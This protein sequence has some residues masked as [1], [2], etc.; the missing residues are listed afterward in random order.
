MRIKR[1]VISIIVLLSLLSYPGRT[2]GQSPPDI[3]WKEIKTSRFQIIFPAELEAEAQ[4]V[5]NMLE[6]FADCQETTMK[7]KYSSIPVV[8]VNQSTVSNGFVSHVPL[9]SHWYS[10]PSAFSGTEWYKTLAVH[11]GRHIVQNRKLNAGFGKKLWSLCLGDVGT[12]TFNFLYVPVWFSEGDAVLSETVFT[13]GGRGRISFFDLWLRTQELSGERFS[14]DRTYLG[15]YND[16]YIFA[17]HYK[18]GYLLVTRAC[19]EYGA[20]VW[21]K[22]LEETGKYVIFPTF[23]KALTNVTGKSIRQLYN[24]TMDEAGA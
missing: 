16:P 3:K 11:E 5:A 21:D 7:S 18:I 12:A 10:T 13:N 6:H 8:L 23:D 2:T 9:M 14:Y 17:D 19:R 4:R 24:D 15:S 1:V 22:V 20:G